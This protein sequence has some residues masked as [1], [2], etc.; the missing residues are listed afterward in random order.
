[1]SKLEDMQLSVSAADVLD[2]II[3][4]DYAGEA[5]AY[6]ANNVTDTET[7]AEESFKKSDNCDHAWFAG[8][9]LKL[10]LGMKYSEIDDLKETIADDILEG[11]FDKIREL[12][13]LLQEYVAEE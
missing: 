1:M 9:W 2:D 13:K 10:F 8:V 7:L 12:I 3:D 5:I 4:A 11:N 6:L